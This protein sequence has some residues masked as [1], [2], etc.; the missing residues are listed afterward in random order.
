M[1]GRS[2]NIA[3]C[4]MSLSTLHAAGP[5]D[6]YVS[7]A[8]DDSDSLDLAGPSGAALARDC[9]MGSTHQIS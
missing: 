4:V 8:T 2:E 9:C 1:P 7:D 3:K 6:G 5:P